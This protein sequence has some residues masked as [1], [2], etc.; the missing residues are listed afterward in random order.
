[1][2]GESGTVSE[3]KMCVCVYTL[4]RGN[5][6]SRKRGGERQCVR[7][8]YIQFKLQQTFVCVHGKENTGDRLGD[9]ARFIHKFPLISHV[10]WLCALFNYLKERAVRVDPIL[11]ELSSVKRH[12][13][14]SKFEHRSLIQCTN[15]KLTIW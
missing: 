10:N 15:G 4:V 7:E 9:R 3:K 6:P 5:P 11:R 1:M 8:R 12:I 13:W 14:D 2:I